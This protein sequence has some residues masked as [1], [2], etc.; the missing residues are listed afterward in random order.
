MIVKSLFLN[1]V[2]LVRRDAQDHMLVRFL[3]L[4][5]DVLASLRDMEALLRFS[6]C[7]DS[8][9]STNV[10]AVISTKVRYFVLYKIR[11]L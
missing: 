6:S 11:S 7:F 10:Q 3:P 2:A 8:S 5:N 1:C 9:R 4:V